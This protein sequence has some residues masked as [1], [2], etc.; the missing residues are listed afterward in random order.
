MAFL[1]NK[2]TK[3]VNEKAENARRVES[4]LSKKH[5]GKAGGMLGTEECWKEEKCWK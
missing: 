3:R 5:H 4:F 2:P 1:G